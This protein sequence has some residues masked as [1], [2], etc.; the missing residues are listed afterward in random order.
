VAASLS[1]TA[2]ERT[3]SP[4]GGNASATTGGK[5]APDR[6]KETADQFIARVN[7]EYKAMYTELSSAQWLSATHITDDSQLVAAKANE[8]YLTQLN[9]WIEQARRFEGED[10]SPQTARAIHM[11]KLM[12]AMPS[13]RDP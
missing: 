1:L 12:T 7:Q 10:M 13:P 3:P 11:L 5:P 9:D 2:C 6:S 8:R 4:E